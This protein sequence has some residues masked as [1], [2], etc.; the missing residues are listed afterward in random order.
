MTEK[1]KPAAEAADVAVVR[2]PT[3]AIDFV[4]EAEALRLEQSGEG[5]RARPIDLEIAG[6][7]PRA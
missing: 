3:G 4:T 2:E 5:R 7:M 1:T 6:S